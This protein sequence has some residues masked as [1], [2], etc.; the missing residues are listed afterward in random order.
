MCV[1]FLIERHACYFPPTFRMLFA[2][3]T[4]VCIFFH[5][6]IVRGREKIKM[7][8]LK[9]EDKEDRSRDYKKLE[10]Y[11]ESRNTRETNL[12]C[13]HE[14]LWLG[15]L[16]SAMKRAELEENHIDKSNY[17]CANTD[18]TGC[19]YMPS[20]EQGTA[21]N[22]STPDNERG[23]NHN[24]LGPTGS[25]HGHYEIQ[26][27]SGRVFDEKI[28]IYVKDTIQITKEMV[29]EFTKRGAK[30]INKFLTDKETRHNRVLVHCYAGMNR[31]VAIIIRY[32][33][34]YQEFT[35]QNAL[36]YIR[37]KNS[38]ERN[39]KGMLTGSNCTFMNVLRE[40]YENKTKRVVGQERTVPDSRQYSCNEG[41]PLT[42]RWG[43]DSPYTEPVIHRPDMEPYMEPC[44]SPCSLYSS[45]TY[46]SP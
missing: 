23:T 42:G 39:I 25:H 4:V 34:D 11:R 31:S 36:N 33:I 45:P 24:N 6:E 5:I 35:F 41:A 38:T 18:A 30:A 10:K 2:F 15:N 29:L 26:Q 12:N 21:F 17:V 37:E 9:D 44:S 40:Y 8:K 16:F 14:N 27:L 22:P 20:K 1:K 19:T 3:C 28:D 32:A 7:L 46:P 13:I 43:A